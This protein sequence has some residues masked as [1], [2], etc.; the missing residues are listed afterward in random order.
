[1]VAGAAL[2][3][4]TAFSHGAFAQTAR[5]GYEA[6]GLPMGAF[7]AYPK[8]TTTVESNDNIYAQTTKKVDDVIWRVQ[9]EVTLVSDWSRHSLTAFAR[10]S[11]N[12]NQDFKNENTDEYSLGADGRIDVLRTTRLLGGAS[13]TNATEPRTSPNAVGAATEPTEYD[14]TKAYVGG[15]H[16]FNRLMVSSRLGYDKY[17]YQ[18]VRALGGTVIDQDFRDHE[19]TDLMGRADYSVSPDTSLFVEITGNQRKYDRVRPAVALTRDSDG[20]TVL[21]GAKFDLTAV[22]RGEVSAGYLKQ[23]FDDVTQKDV[24]GL[25]VRTQV[26]WFPTR[27]TSVT[28]VANRNIQDSAVANSAAYVAEDVSL[29]LDHDLLRNVHLS[30]DAGYGR[31]DYKDINRRDRRVSAGASATYLLNRHV[32]VSLAYRYMDRDIERGVGVAYKVNKVQ[33]ALTLQF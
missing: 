28:L 12:R 2:I 17:D 25:A 23:S 8:L 26:E 1:L 11:F 15:E 22:A 16:E 9:P 21:A 14:L 30:G 32:G 5:S 24:K 27:L 29:R 6:K 13:F 31:D 33:A 7:T 3:A 20:V 4:A 18:D 19:T 10:A